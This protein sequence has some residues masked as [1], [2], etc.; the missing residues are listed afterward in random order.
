MAR[1]MREGAPVRQTTRN[2]AGEAEVARGWRTG[3]VERRAL[4]SQRPDEAPGG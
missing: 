1:R 3:A 4:G 2:G